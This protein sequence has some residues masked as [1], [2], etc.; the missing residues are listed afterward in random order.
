[1]H[2][3]RVIVWS[4]PKNCLLCSALHERH[5]FGED[6]YNCNLVDHNRV[7]NPADGRPSWCPLVVEGECEYFGSGV[8]K[9]HLG[10]LSY[11]TSCGGSMSMAL[12]V[13]YCCFC[14]KKIK[15]VEE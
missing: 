5:E 3:T 1:M 12:K 8:P 14:Q 13:P 11:K 7:L 15:Y 6:L 4:V 9:N 10:I 2:A